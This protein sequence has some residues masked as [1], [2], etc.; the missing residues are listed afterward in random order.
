MHSPKLKVMN[1]CLQV[2]LT[3]NM[4]GVKMN[5]STQLQDTVIITTSLLKHLDLFVSDCAA[6]KQLPKGQ[7]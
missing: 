7:N 5:I 1:M 4:I 6:V 2:T 3:D